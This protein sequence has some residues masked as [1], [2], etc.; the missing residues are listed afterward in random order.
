MLAAIGYWALL[1]FAGCACGLLNTLASSGSAVSLPLLVMLGLPEG[2]ANAT[3]RLPVMIGSIM[4]TVSFAR[5]GALDWS[6]GAKLA[7]VAAMGSIVGALLAERLGNRQM[8]LVIT[9]AVLF[10]L[11]LLFT[12][13]KQALAKDIDGLPSVSYRAM[14]AI[15]LVGIWLG[16]IVLDGATYLLLV[17]MLMCHYRLAEANALK[18][19]LIAVT[20]VIPIAL[21]GGAGEIA[22]AEGGVLAAGSV[23]G[24]HIGARLSLQPLARVWAFRILVVAIVLE[25]A[26]LGW[27]YSA[28]YRAAV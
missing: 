21:F 12:K 19:L 23:V 5:A 20:T 22:W 27:H 18:V 13:I 7:P 8:G 24:G 9:A 10:A 15:F 4:A 26:H 6:A 25:L 17:L 14:A 11:I 1:A 2:A 3:N 28:P 16:F